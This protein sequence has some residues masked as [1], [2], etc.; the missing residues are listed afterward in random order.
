AVNGGPATLPE[1]QI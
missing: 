1:Y